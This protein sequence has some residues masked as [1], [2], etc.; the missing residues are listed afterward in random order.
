MTKFLGAEACSCFNV[1]VKNVVFRF[2]LLLIQNIVSFWARSFSK[3]SFI[4]TEVAMK[5]PENILNKMHKLHRKQE[6]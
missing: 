6:T 2:G 5:N 1:C 3:K 4:S